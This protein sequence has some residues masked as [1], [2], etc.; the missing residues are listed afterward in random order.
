[1][2]PSVLGA[3]LLQQLGEMGMRIRGERT[4]TELVGQSEGLSIVALGLFE[5]ARVATRSDPTEQ[6]QTPG[7]VTTLLM[8]PGKAQALA[9]LP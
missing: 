1:M 8:A 3:Y 5:I 2:I 7:L 9:C 6:A 4:H